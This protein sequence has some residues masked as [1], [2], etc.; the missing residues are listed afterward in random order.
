MSLEV[1][2]VVLQQLNLSYNPP[3]TL[4][5]QYLLGPANE[6]HLSI[7]QSESVMS[8]AQ[9]GQSMPPT[10]NSQ[11]VL[12]V[13]LVGAASPLKGINSLLSFCRINLLFASFKSFRACQPQ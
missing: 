5:Y 11:T 7:L 8:S 1:F 4:V 9:L 3:L 10:R 13:E 6:T 2:G 12:S